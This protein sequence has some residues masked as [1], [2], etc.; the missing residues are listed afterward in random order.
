M[1]ALL[2]PAISSG[3]FAR[4]LVIRSADR[5]NVGLA[6]K[7]NQSIPAIATIVFP[8]VVNTDLFNQKQNRFLWYVRCPTPGRRNKAHE[9]CNTRSS[10]RKATWNTDRNTS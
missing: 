9:Y 6:P 5:L 2:I 1:P 3:L 10:Y 4:A 8:K 7:S